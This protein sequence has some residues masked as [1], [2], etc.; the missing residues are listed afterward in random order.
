MQEALACTDTEDWDSPLPDHIRKRWNAWLKHLPQLEA[1][2]IPRCYHIL[3]DR[4]TVYEIHSFGDASNVGVGAVTFL[5]FYKDGSWNCAF[6]RGKGHILP[7]N[8][9][10]T[11]ARHE[12]EAAVMATHIHVNVEEALKS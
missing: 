1:V 3:G 5:R 9:S 12:L 2:S 8:V 11:T 7:K 4:A 10:W 6:I